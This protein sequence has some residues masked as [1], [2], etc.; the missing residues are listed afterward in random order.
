LKSIVEQL[1][2]IFKPKSIA[3][4]GA[5]NT[6]GKWG[7]LMVDRPLKTG[8]S[9]AIYPVNPKKGEII[10]LRTYQSILDIPDPVELKGG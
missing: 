3:I 10:G 5:S 9:G 8:Y 2:P 4:L 1:D 7:Y 6:L